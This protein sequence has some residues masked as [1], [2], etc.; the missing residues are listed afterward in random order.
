MTAMR[1]RCVRRLRDA[2]RWLRKTS[3]IV[4]GLLFTMKIPT[5]A[6]GTTNR[7]AAG[8]L[9]VEPWSAEGAKIARHDAWSTRDISAGDS[10]AHPRPRLPQSS[11]LLRVALVQSQRG[12]ECRRDA[13]RNAAALFMSQDGLHGLRPSRSR[14]AA[15]LVAAHEQA[16][17][18]NVRSTGCLP[19]L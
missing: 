6:C 9:L 8:P 10:R 2:N 3:G 14:C 5:R 7:R 15:G 11:G 16:A 1:C 17:V 13:G 19:T 4:S 18:V 12:H